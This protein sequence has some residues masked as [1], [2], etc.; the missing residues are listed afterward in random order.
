M[1]RETGDALGVVV[2]TF[3]RQPAAA[4]G[5]PEQVLKEAG[6]NLK[7]LGEELRENMNT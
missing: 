5:P 1:T 2:S 3:R 4:K 7:E 6:F